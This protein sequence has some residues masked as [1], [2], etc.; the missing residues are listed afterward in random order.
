MKADASTLWDILHDRQAAFEL[1]RL[2]D[3][4]V[5]AEGGDLISDTLKG[6][7]EPASVDDKASRDSGTLGLIS[8]KFNKHILKKKVLFFIPVLVVYPYQAAAESQYL[9]EGDEDAVVYLCQWRANEARSKHCAS[10]DAQ[11]HSGEELYQ[12]HSSGV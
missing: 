7:A 12:F 4:Y 2:G 11:C 5:V 8:Y 10:E 1:R 3:G 9:A 6:V